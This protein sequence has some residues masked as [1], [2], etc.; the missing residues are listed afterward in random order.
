TPSLS[1]FPYTTLFRSINS[2]DNNFHFIMT[3]DR[4][5]GYYSSVQEGGHGK[6]DIYRITFLDRTLQPLLEAPR[7]SIARGLVLTKED[8][9][10]RSEE[11]TSELQSR[12]DL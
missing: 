1:P 5:H 9:L 11:H 2:P 6:S 12:F 10:T 3:G 4:K 7:Q 8:S